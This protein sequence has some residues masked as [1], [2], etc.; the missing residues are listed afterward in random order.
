MRLLEGDESLLFRDPLL[1]SVDPH[2]FGVDH[3]LVSLLVVEPVDID[4]GGFGSSPHHLGVDDDAGD[5]TLIAELLQTE[6]G[7]IIV[8]SD[9]GSVF[10]VVVDD[11]LVILELDGVV[12]GEAN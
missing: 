4:V 5:A 11:G 8:I 9:L 12:H 7:S 10:L 6:R 3:G 2:G 1:V